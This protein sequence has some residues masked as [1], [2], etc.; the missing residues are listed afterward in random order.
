MSVDSSLAAATPE[1]RRTFLPDER[2]LR[3][4]KLGFDTAAIAKAA[5]C[6]ESAIAN[7]L[8]RLRDAAVAG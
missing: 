3:F 8:A 7:R 1:T 6:P 4:W 2:L 5:G